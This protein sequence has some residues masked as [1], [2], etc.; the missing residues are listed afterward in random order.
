MAAEPGIPG[1][2]ILK[3]IGRGGTGTVYRARH[4]ASSRDV[5]VKVLDQI[6]LD[7]EEATAF[8]QNFARLAEFTDDPTIVTVLGLGV[9]P[10]GHPYLVLEYVDGGSLGAI[11][12]TGTLDPEVAAAVMAEVGAA[13]DRLHQRGVVHGDITPDNVLLTKS[14]EPRLSGFGIAQHFAL[15]PHSAALGVSPVHGAPEVLGGRHRSEAA[16]VWALGS[17]LLEAVSRMAPLDGS[18]S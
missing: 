2:T 6:V 8:K 4:D 9:L 14:G 5:A 11:T 17:V 12:A 1:L 16:D 7:D 13:V 18:S 15:G 3:E 10:N